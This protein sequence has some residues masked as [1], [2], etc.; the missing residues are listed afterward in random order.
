M[1]ETP[2]ENARRGYLRQIAHRIRRRLKIEK[3]DY[4]VFPPDVP[5]RYKVY[6]D[7]YPEFV[8]D[9]NLLGYKETAKKWGMSHG[10]VCCL[11]HRLRK[12]IC[13]EKSFLPHK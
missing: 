4:D 7:R 5:Q 8:V 6:P 12:G 2:V 1:S 3:P 9:C 10:G 11:M 13:Y